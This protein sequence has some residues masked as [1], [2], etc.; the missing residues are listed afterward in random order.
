[1]YM[2]FQLK[3]IYPGKGTRKTETKFRELN[4]NTTEAISGKQSSNP[5]EWTWKL[6]PQ[7]V[8]TVS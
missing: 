6:C 2:L 1:M 8:F 5:V 3:H 7:M 4:G